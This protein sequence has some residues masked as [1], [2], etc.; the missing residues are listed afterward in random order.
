MTHRKETSTNS[1]NRQVLTEFCG[2]QY[3]INLIEGRWKLIILYKLERKELRFTE[4][5]KQLP[6]VTDRMLTRQL[7]ELERD[8]LINRRVFAAVPLKVVYALTEE[9][10]SLSPIWTSLEHWGLAHRLKATE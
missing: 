6:N 3:A 7:K 4:L 1:I 5:K 8:K 2:L 9:G 10:R